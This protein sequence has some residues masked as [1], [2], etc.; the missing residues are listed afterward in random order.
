MLHYVT[1]TEN[2]PSNATHMYFLILD[3]KVYQL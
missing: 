2:S 1:S 3:R